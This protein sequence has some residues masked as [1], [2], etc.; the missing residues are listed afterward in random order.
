MDGDRATLVV[1]PVDAGSRKMERP[2]RPVVADA[3][4]PGD[5]KALVCHVSV[6]HV[7]A[8]GGSIVVVITGVT[9]LPLGVQPARGVRVL[10]EQHRDTRP[11]P[12]Q[13]LGVDR[14]R[15]AT[16]QLG[17]LRGLE[18]PVR[19]GHRRQQVSVVHRP[20]FLFPIIPIGFTA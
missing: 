12:G 15:R 20:A 9:T 17:A 2:A 5:G 6:D 4:H 11:A 7:N 16:R 19:G 10:P 1:H 13:H 8:D 3:A 18:S 14:R